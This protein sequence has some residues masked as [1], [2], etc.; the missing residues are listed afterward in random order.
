M[1][2]V[3]YSHTITV[4]LTQESHKYTLRTEHLSMA[5][6]ASQSPNPATQIF[7]AVTWW[8]HLESLFM[9][10]SNGLEHVTAFK[11]GAWGRLD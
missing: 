9:G 4:R 7:D 2:A 5:S 10:L 1:S 11:Y 8:T 3:H 6:P